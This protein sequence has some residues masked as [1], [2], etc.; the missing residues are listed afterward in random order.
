[1]NADFRSTAAAE[2]AGYAA[3]P[4]EAA[5]DIGIQDRV[6]P[7]ALWDLHFVRA[8]HEARHDV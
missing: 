8:M 4:R 5:F 1:M 7:M 6:N 3:W 2:F